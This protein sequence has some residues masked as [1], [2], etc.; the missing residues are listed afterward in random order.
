M[1]A[2]NL[3]PV[4]KAMRQL[5]PARRI[6]IAA[7]DDAHLP[8]NIGLGVAQEAAESIGGL[9]AVPVPE[10][11]RGN[12]GADFADLTRQEAAAIIAATLSGEA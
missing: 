5:F 8:E 3:E 10:T 2:R 7:D 11:P 4:A 1:S 6:I 9:L 12:S